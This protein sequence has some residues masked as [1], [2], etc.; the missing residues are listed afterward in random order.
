MLMK[1]SLLSLLVLLAVSS[2]SSEMMNMD[3]V[4]NQ[5]RNYYESGRYAEEVEKIIN[6]TKN[7]LSVAEFPENAAVVF[8]VDDTVLSSYEYTRLMGF[9]FNY[10]SWIQYMH[11]GRL[12]SIPQVKR[13]YEWLLEKEVKI[14]FLTGRRAGECDA[15][16][17]NLV[18]EGFTQFDTLI[19]RPDHQFSMPASEYK[20]AQRQALTES[21]YNI[22]ACFGD[23]WS[24]LSG[25]N[26]GLKVKLPNYLYHID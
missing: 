23:Q 20:P 4:R 26:T 5:M 9:G 24:D 25:N 18:K 15:T 2:C 13:M 19:C 6:E 22:I 8:D 21:G 14:I 10:S 7:E 3:T 12:S 16:Y 11:D 17:N 1:K